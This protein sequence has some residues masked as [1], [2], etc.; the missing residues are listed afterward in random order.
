MKIYPIYPSFSSGQFFELA[1]QPRRRF[2]VA[3]YQQRNN[4][5]LTSVSGVI[6]SATNNVKAELVDGKYVFQS[7]EAETQARFDEDWE[8]PTITIKP[9]I[10]EMRSGAY[11]AVA[12][13]VDPRGEPLTNLGRRCSTHQAV[14]GW[15]P[16]SDSMALI[17]ACHSDSHVSRVQLHGRW[18]F[19]PRSDS[20]HVPLY[21]GHPSPSRWRAWRTTRRTG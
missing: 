16:D 10:P 20:S 6:V 12:Y 3:I 2:S 19:L 5:S 14:F 17:V 8:W 15:P 1:V 9:N 13:E 21:E 11:V 4:E 18:L 7:V